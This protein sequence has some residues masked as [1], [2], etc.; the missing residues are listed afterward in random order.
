MTDRSD[1]MNL[2]SYVIFFLFFLAAAPCPRAEQN[3]AV[4]PASNTTV[5]TPPEEYLRYLN[6]KAYAAAANNL[7]ICEQNDD[8]LEIANRIQSW[9]CSATACKDKNSQEKVMACFK[10]S[11][12]TKDV[13]NQMGQVISTFCSLIQTPN[14]LLRQALLDRLSNVDES[15]LV[16]S[17][18]WL[19]ALQGS[20]ASCTNYIKGFVGPYGRQW[21]PNWY[22]AL[23]GCRVLSKERTLEQ[24]EKDFSAW[25]EVEHGAGHC[26][27]IANIEM[28]DACDTKE[29][30]SPFK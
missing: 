8:C 6:L 21:T 28:R 25:Y 24:E 7:T 20:S 16:E 12:S 5:K 9:S 29:A 13:E 18:A 27:D 1:T 22:S 4:T 2:R 26:A 30:P 23:S 17:G 14:S 15:K 3:P 10:D 19:M 11:A